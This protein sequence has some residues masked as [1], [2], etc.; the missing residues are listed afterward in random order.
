MDS[1][2][3]QT[4]H[5]LPAKPGASLVRLDGEDAGKAADEGAEAG[6]S[7]GKFGTGEEALP[8]LGLEG[9]KSES[10]VGGAEARGGDHSV[11]KASMGKIDLRAGFA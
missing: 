3:C 5:A 7:G 10:T 8:Q 1:R 11:V 9:N 6:L 4:A 2:N